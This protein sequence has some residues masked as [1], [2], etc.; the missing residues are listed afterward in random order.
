MMRRIRILRETRVLGATLALVVPFAACNFDVTNPGPVQ[1]EFLNDSDAFEA[2]VNGMGRDLSDGLNY[3]AFHGSMVVRELFPTGGTGQFGISPRNADGFLDANDQGTPWNL[4]QRARWVA[5]DGLRRFAENMEA[6]EFSRSEMVAQAHLWAGYSNRAL[7]ENMCQA[8]IDG[9]APLP[10]STFLERA[11]QHFSDAI[12]VASA[13]GSSTIAT[14]A[15]AA[16]ASV[17]V[18][19][20]DWPGAVSDAGGIAT[21]FVYEMPYFDRGDQSEYNRIAHAS[22]NDPYKTHTVWGTIYADYY[23]AS[24]DPRVAWVDTGLPGDGGVAC[25]GQ[26]PFYQQIKFPDKDAPI[27]LSSGAEMRLI[28][29]ENA[30]I[31]GSWESALSIIN[32]LRAVYGVD[33]WTASGSAEAWARLKRERGIQLWLE[34]RRLGDFYRW[35]QEGTPGALDPLE[36]L[37]PE[38]YLLNQ[39]LCFPIPDGERDTNPNV[40]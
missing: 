16:R 4:T 40:S 37:S 31:G 33:P 22:A 15:R 19:L 24:G 36:I 39:D 11:E 1:D 3:L 5:E 29:A 21:S 28:E 34:G 38:S 25:C 7:G 23:L 2:V 10:R 20:G 35:N 12:D 8:V 26:V 6:S 17:R 32:D 18:Q 27:T 13:A 14:A 9:G 30:L